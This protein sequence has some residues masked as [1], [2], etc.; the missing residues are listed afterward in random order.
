[1]KIDQTEYKGYKVMVSLEHDDTVNLWNGRYRILDRENVVVYES[2]SPPV[3]DEAEARSA[4]HAE[5]RAWVDDDPD[6]L[7]GT[8]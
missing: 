4:A 8:H 2:F 6:A 3:A 5:A 7:S 1:M